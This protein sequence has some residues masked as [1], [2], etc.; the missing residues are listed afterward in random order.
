MWNIFVFIDIGFDAKSFSISCWFND[1]LI[2]TC[3]C[4]YIYIWQFPF[5]ATSL[6]CVHKFCCFFFL[7]FHHF[8]VFSILAVISIVV[9][10]SEMNGSTIDAL[11]H[12]RIDLASYYYRLW[13]WYLV[14]SD[15]EKTPHME[16]YMVL[17]PNVS[18]LMYRLIARANNT[19][20]NTCI[21]GTKH[22]NMNTSV[23]HNKLREREM[24]H[25]FFPAAATKR[26][27]PHAIRFSPFGFFTAINYF[28]RFKIVIN[29]TTSATGR[30]MHKWQLLSSLLHM[31]VRSVE[32]RV[33]KTSNTL[34]HSSKLNGFWN[35]MLITPSNK[36]A[37][38]YY[39]ECMFSINYNPITFKLR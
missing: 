34:K 3:I 5:Y 30:R 9:V 25:I 4:I 26:Q 31:Y 32:C 1:I 10:V 16:P 29:K 15:K 17:S 18:P 27:C 8:N 21:C 12:A 6:F 38:I 20:Q 14:V 19:I 2:N 37:F 35:A 11:Q 13:L 28:M 23:T 22:A 39:S 33:W 24:M 7:L 36:I